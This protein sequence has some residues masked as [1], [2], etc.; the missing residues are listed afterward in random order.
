MKIQKFAVCLAISMI[1]GAFGIFNTFGQTS[2]FSYQG[3]LTDAGV[4]ANGTYIMQFSLWD[5]ASGG[6]SAGTLSDLNVN[7]R[8][9]V[10]NVQLDF[11]SAAV[12]GNAI[13]LEFAVKKLP[14][15]AYTT[16][17]P[18]QQIL[19]APHAI[20]SGTAGSSDDSAKL[21]GVDAAR[22]VQS[23][24]NGNVAVGGDLTVTGSTT[25]DTVNATTQFNLGGDR[26]LSSDILGNLNLGTNSGTP[27]VPPAFSELEGKSLV[28][29][30][31]N[32]VLGNWAGAA[33]TTG[34]VNTFVGYAAGNRDDT[35][36]GNSFIGHGAGFLTTSG[37]ANTFV[38]NGSGTYNITGLENS[39]FGAASGGNATAGSFNTFGGT[40]AGFKNHQDGNSFFGYKSGYANT[41]GDSNAF[42]GYLSGLSNTVGFSNTFVGSFAGQ[43]NVGGDTNSFFGRQSGFLNLSGSQNS[44]FGRSTGYSNTTGSFNTFYGVNSGNANTLGS[45]NAFFG[46]DTGTTN[47][48]GDH[49]SLFGFGANVGVDGLTNA[50]AIGANA[51]VSQSNSLVLGNNANVG[52]GTSTPTSKLSVAGM[53]ETTTGGIKFPDGSI[54]TTAGGGGSGVTDLNGLNGSVNLAAGSNVTITP[55]GNTLTIAS[56]LS[57]PSGI[58]NQ[59]TQQTSANFNIDGTGTANIFDANQ[60]Y[61]LGYRLLYS[62]GESTNLYVGRYTGVQGLGANDNTFL[63]T[64][65]GRSTTTGGGNTFV[66]AN[67]GYNNI[68]GNS[69][70]FLGSDTGVSPTGSR[71]TLIGAAAGDGLQAGSNNSALGAFV[72]LGPNLNFATAIG[73]GSSVTTD[74]T[75]VIGRP[76]DTVSIPGTLTK[77]AGSFRIDHPLDPKNKYLYHS[78]VESPDMMNVYNGNITTDASG[79]ATVTLPRYFEALNKDF[80]YQLTVIGT[81]AQAIV[82]EEVSGNK[83]KIKTDKPNVKVS[84]QVTGIRN[85]PYAEKNRIVPEVEKPAGEKGKLQNPEAFEGDQ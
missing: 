40:Y 41:T 58:L 59:T 3:K 2:A 70:T 66:G 83:F 25:F 69:N 63:G 21:G 36:T 33:L 31:L 37:G 8:D 47:T 54:Q 76:T 6:T 56:T 60:Y 79:N 13:Y 10:F 55:S 14:G 45:S 72:H 17:S 42:F 24:A 84:W 22:F 46:N 16:L 53:I 81:F 12:S 85:D 39:Y 26:V 27:P 77:A 35:G 9:G 11:G 4:P 30:N 44:F 20:K 62:P 75:I 7:V 32:T 71:N 49:L 74:N 18:R 61:S 19:S 57:A 5:A 1:L 64:S 82:V 80:R 68:D 34:A 43:S 29:A 23:D 78:F 73:A 51:V 38:G 28:P 50:S 52:I 48:T 15:D 67:A 65:T